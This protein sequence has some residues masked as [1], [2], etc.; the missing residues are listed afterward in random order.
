MNHGPDGTGP[1]RP[2][3]VT[4]APDGLGGPAPDEPALRRLL[5]SA[6]DDLEP[7]GDTLEQLRRAIPARR[8]RKRQAAVGMA[9]AALFIGTAIPALL[10][11]S[12]SGGSDPN[13]AM[14]GQTSQAQGGTG[15]GRDKGTTVGKGGGK[16][17]GSTTAEPGKEPGK[18]GV[19]DRKEGHP[20]G[21]PD[22][23]AGPS[24]SAPTGTPACSTG[25]LG[26]ANGTVNAP[27]SAGIVSGTFRVVNVSG[28]ACTVSGPGSV[29][30]TA[31]GAA[32]PARISAVRHTAGDGAATALP[33]PSL[34]VASLVLEPGAAYEEKFAFVPSETCPATGGEGTDGGS[35]TQDPSPV[36]TPTQEASAS[37]TGGP[38]DTG[39]G[40]P[41]AT[42]Q[43][44]TEGGTAE[45]SV[46]VTH[47]AQDGAPS[48]TAVVPGACAGTVYYTGLLAGA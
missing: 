22:G 30:P 44:V 38:T 2:G 9:A 35:G 32:D 26:S 28:T 29:T 20:A 19:E 39:T 41:A 21:S 18:G 3:T 6:V 27:D 42:T 40:T 34:E 45:G 33:D 13:T 14:A 46:T 5:H 43:L 31:Q 4:D 7:R 48:A 37:T 15:Q 17:T 12:N 25:Q 47:T 16:D 1:E 11:V 23:S 8:A 24:A 10:H 36:P